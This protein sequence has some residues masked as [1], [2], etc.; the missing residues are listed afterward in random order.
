MKLNRRELIQGGAA[1]AAATSSPL[2]WA[3][4]SVKIGYVSPQTGPL[5]P[6]GE[7]DKW[8][9]DQMKTALMQGS[10]RARGAFSTALD[11]LTTLLHERLR[12]AVARGNAHDATSTA[13]A[14]D[15]VERAKEHATGNVN[16]QLITSE[17][18]RK[19]EGLL[20]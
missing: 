11:A 20:A 6:F 9:I 19:L 16:P 10:A 17:L 2:L 3:A 13:R 8:V 12:A 4:D 18:L 1:L 15:V 7:A 14:L 5:A